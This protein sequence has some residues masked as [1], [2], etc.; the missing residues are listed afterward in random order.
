MKRT[1]CRPGP[2]LLLSVAA[3][4]FLLGGCSKE[5]ERNLAPMMVARKA[6]KPAGPVAAPEPAKGQAK[7]A[8][9]AKVQDNALRY[10]STGKDNGSI[11][12]PGALQDLYSPVGKRNPFLPYLRVSKEGKQRDLGKVPPLQRTDLSEFRYVGL[13]QT[14][15]GAVA[16]LETGD[17]K[18][19]P[20]QVG[21]RLGREGGVVTKITSKE[22]SIREEAADKA[23]N[24]VVREVL[25]KNKN[26]NAGGKQ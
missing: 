18:G 23:G 25:I 11:F 12:P 13:L 4:A 7:G 15:K 20:V 2:A 10:A 6:G 17:G 26:A 8:P 5:P 21:A 3:L 1:S 24:P 16:L 22:I 9:A 14:R 19:Y